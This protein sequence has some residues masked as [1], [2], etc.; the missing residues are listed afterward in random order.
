M[1]SLIFIAFVAASLSMAAPVTQEEVVFSLSH[2]P[3]CFQAQAKSQLSA[4]YG[5]DRFSVTVNS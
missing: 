3:H 2:V 5:S 4:W 1:R